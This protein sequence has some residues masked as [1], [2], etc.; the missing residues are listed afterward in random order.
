MRPNT[1]RLKTTERIKSK[2]SR[3]VELGMPFSFRSNLGGK[4]VKND[5]HTQTH[6]VWAV[7]V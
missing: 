5:A 1:D 4:E 2:A 7:A 3:A 6:A